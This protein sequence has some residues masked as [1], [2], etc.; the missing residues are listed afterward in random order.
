MKKKKASLFSLKKILTSLCSVVL[1]FAMVLSSSPN[2]HQLLVDQVKAC[3]PGSATCTCA[4]NEVD[5]GETGV[6]IE[7]SFASLEFDVSDDAVNKHTITFPGALVTDALITYDYTYDANGGDSYVT[8]GIAGIFVNF[9]GDKAFV[10]YSG[11]EKGEITYYDMEVTI[12]APLSG[13]IPVSNH[14]VTNEP[15]D[16][17]DTS[18]TIIV[19]EPNDPITQMEL[20]VTS[21]P[22]DSGVSSEV[23]IVATA[24]DVG[25][26][27]LTNVSIDS[28]SFVNSVVANGSI[29]TASEVSDTSNDNVTFDVTNI[30]AFWNGDMDF[31]FEVV[32]GDN[33]I[34][35][36]PKTIT[37]IDAKPTISLS[38]TDPLEDGGSINASFSITANDSV[39]YNRSYTRT[40]TG[41]VGE[42][43][44]IVGSLSGASDADVDALTAKTPFETITVTV[45]ELSKADQP[46]T[47]QIAKSGGRRRLTPIVDFTSAFIKEMGF[48]YDAAEYADTALVGVEC[49][50]VAV[51]S[52]GDPINPES[53]SV[54]SAYDPS[55]VDKSAALGYLQLRLGLALDLGFPLTN[56]LGGGGPTVRTSINT[57]FSSSAPST[58]PDVDDGIKRRDELLGQLIID[59]TYFENQ[60]EESIANGE[61]VLSEL[62]YVRVQQRQIKAMDY[63]L[64]VGIVNELLGI[65]IT[66]DTTESDAI[67]VELESAT[68][69]AEE[70]LESQLELLDK[71]GLESIDEMEELFSNTI[72]VGV[73]DADE[74][75][76]LRNEYYD[77][78]RVPG[79][80][81]DPT[82]T[83]TEWDKIIKEVI[84]L[85]K[86]YDKAIKEIKALQLLFRRTPAPDTEDTSDQIIYFQPRFEGF[87]FT[88]DYTPSDISDAGGTE[89]ERSEV[90]DYFQIEFGLGQRTD[91]ST[92]LGGA[93]VPY[94]DID[95]GFRSSTGGDDTP[96]APTI[97]IEH[98]AAQGGP[99][100]SVL[101]D[102]FDAGTGGDYNV[103]LDA[104]G[105]PLA[106]SGIDIKGRP[107]I[108]DFLYQ[109]FNLETSGETSTPSGTSDTDDQSSGTPSSAGFIFSVTPG[110]TS[111]F[112]PID[113]SS[114]LNL[115]PYVPYDYD[116]GGSTYGTPLSPS[117]TEGGY[118]ID[119]DLNF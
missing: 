76:K 39:D 57:G 89:E 102:L 18:L 25:S 93:G 67:D 74:Y 80:G 54:P 24:N 55:A 22:K 50:D 46:A 94:F 58:A 48:L 82:I 42:P 10:T 85:G 52:A 4:G 8:D 70:T 40:Y 19:A 110:G 16:Y 62:E 15:F 26:D 88:V 60:F 104:A 105:Y 27:D 28:A 114:G 51:N 32:D 49:F 75:F 101:P 36:I 12:T 33:P 90:S 17:D 3:S 47:G 61:L 23:G 106:P 100:E 9:S 97:I 72:T 99:I 34:Q 113:T 38:T 21:I 115:T 117:G 29:G 112:E 63:E 86:D 98:P 41:V 66:L 107:P 108:D 92:G 109:F 45:T 20:S 73:L 65:Y 35:Y 56:I 87:S 7:I 91:L 83:V 1:V 31:I 13:T 14:L 118:Y 81:Y 103:P 64:F 43:V 2:L 37:V 68:N 69:L 30:P 77:E 53:T 95:L 84:S 6:V 59:N 44:N 119:V 78:V 11:L 5:P 96:E 116:A 79:A 111:T 71:L